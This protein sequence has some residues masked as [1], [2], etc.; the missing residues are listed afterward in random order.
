MSTGLASTA[1]DQ[2]YEILGKYELKSGSLSK[3]VRS[4]LKKGRFPLRPSQDVTLATIHG[5]EMQ[6]AQE[7]SKTDCGAFYVQARPKLRFK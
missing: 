4:R 5:A 6:C 3:T 7:C 1:D 2:K